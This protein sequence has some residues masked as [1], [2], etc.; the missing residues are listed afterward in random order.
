[1]GHWLTDLNDGEACQIV[2]TSFL[3]SVNLLPQLVTQS[4]GYKP[5]HDLETPNGARLEV[6][7]DILATLTNNLAIEFERRKKTKDGDYYKEKSGILVSEADF[8]AVMYMQDRGLFMKNW[9]LEDIHPQILI[10]KKSELLDYIE[11]NKLRI[12][13]MGD[14]KLTNG[15]VIPISVLKDML[16]CDTIDVP[17]SAE[18]MQDLVYRLIIKLKKVNTNL[19]KKYGK[20]YQ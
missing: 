3:Q 18:N 15:Y 9:R 5:S 16:W 19:L 14:G 11:N 13:P 17:F 12:V 20:L 2:V 4:S 6:K 10:L 7:F 8:W 1:M